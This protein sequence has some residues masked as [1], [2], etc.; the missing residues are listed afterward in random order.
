MVGREVEVEV[1]FGDWKII[2]FVSKLC[3]TETPNHHSRTPFS[4]VKGSIGPLLSHMVHGSGNHN[5]Q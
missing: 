1:A 3:P 4:I 2:R 5:S